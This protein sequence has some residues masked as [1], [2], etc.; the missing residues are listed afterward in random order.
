[1][2][3]KTFVGDNEGEVRAIYVEPD[4]WGESIGTALLERGIEQFHDEVDTV[5]LEML[6]GNEV[7]H[8]F[9]ESY[10]FE[11]TGTSEFEIEG[12]PYPTIVYR[13]RL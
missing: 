6:S 10:G 9:Y 12:T 7:G 13:L 11:R 3:T 5:C 4:Y 1:M 2:E 8:Q